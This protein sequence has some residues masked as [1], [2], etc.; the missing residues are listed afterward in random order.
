MCILSLFLE[1]LETKISQE[2]KEGHGKVRKKAE[3][4][5]KSWDL[6]YPGTWYLL[7]M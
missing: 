1:D 6:S 7:L 3:L 2:I 5:K 4:G